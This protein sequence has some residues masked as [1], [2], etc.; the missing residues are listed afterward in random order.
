L[1]LTMPTI[2][3]KTLPR[4]LQTKMSLGDQ[5]LARPL[6]DLNA[7]MRDLD[8]N[9]L[10]IQI[11]YEEGALVAFNIAV[12]PTGRK[13]VRVLTKSIEHFKHTFGVKKFDLTWKQIFKLILPHD[14]PF[15][16][17][18]DIQAGLNC[19]P[20]LVENLT[21]AKHLKVIQAAQSGRGGT[22]TFTRASYEQFLEARR[23]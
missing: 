13:E 18:L 22:P 14:K 3:Q 17:G 4:A 2:L 20:S 16:T 6:G 11:A 10:E 23:L 9:W 21:L 12:D 19:Y 7:A 5:R 15:V 8:L 1:E